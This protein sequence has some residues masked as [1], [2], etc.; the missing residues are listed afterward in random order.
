MH[1]MKTPNGGLLGISRPPHM[2]KVLKH[3]MICIELSSWVP[4][5][6]GVTA[7]CVN[8]PGLGF[9]AGASLD[10]GWE[11][12]K[13]VFLGYSSI[14][15]NVFRYVPGG[16]ENPHDCDRQTCLVELTQLHSNPRMCPQSQGNCGRVRKSSLLLTSGLGE[17]S[18]L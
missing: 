3:R 7:N 9:R 18:E 2:L 17:V 14:S 15:G 8:F 4:H 12:S 11:S 16:A 5:V 10:L 6:G 13:L 1:L